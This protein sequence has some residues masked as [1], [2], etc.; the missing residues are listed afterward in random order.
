MNFIARDTD[1]AIRALIFMAKTSKDVLTVDEIVKEEKLP[2]RFLRRILQKL[3][4]KGVLVSY[5]GSGGGFSFSKK[6]EDI[7][8]T[9][10]IKIFQGTIDLTNCLL[11]GKSCP[12]V[13]KCAL[14]KGLKKIGRSLNKELESITIV[15]LL[16][17]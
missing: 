10:I 13:K 1:Y 15:S 2:E 11:Q 4:K 14:R 17:E 3:A 7:K 12:N 5:K 9:D 6:P 16:K 8:F